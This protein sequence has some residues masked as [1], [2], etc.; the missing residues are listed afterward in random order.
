MWLYKSYREFILEATGKI[1]KEVSTRDSNVIDCGISADSNY[2]ISEQL[3]TGEGPP[4]LVANA[5]VLKAPYPLLEGRRRQSLPRVPGLLRG[6]LRAGIENGENRSSEQLFGWFIPYR[7]GH[8]DSINIS[9]SA[10]KILRF[11]VS[12]WPTLHDSSQSCTVDILRRASNFLQKTPYEFSSVST[13]NGAYANLEC[14]WNNKELCEKDPLIELLIRQARQLRTILD[15]LCTQPRSVLNTEHR[16]LKL[17]NVRRIDRKSVQWLTARPGRNAAERAGVNQRILAPKRYDTIATLENK[18]LRA[19]VA[20][21]VRETQHLLNGNKK[22]IVGKTA[23]EAHHFR[24]RRIET[25]LRE[26]KV[27]EAQSSVRPNFPL[28]FDPRYNKI[29]RAWLALRRAS[30]EFELDWMWQHR[31]FMEILGI[32]I[33]MILHRIMDGP[34]NN[35]LVAHSPLLRTISATNQ[36]SYLNFDENIGMKY[37]Q[38]CPKTNRIRS[39]QFEI[40]KQNDQ[41]PLGAVATFRSPL[42]CATIW[43]N[44]PELFESSTHSLGFGELPWSDITPWEPQIKE[45]ANRIISEF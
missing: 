29:W 30:S 19:F 12:K 44:V 10:G 17:Q 37:I 40:A 39:Y 31:T 16:M 35:G 9:V 24:A 21:T 15:D 7:I 23:L 8:E 6:N 5:H 25:M 13:F 2:P 18:V 22:N 43:W 3:P 32:R 4:L 14:I 27:P 11:D 20:L 34:P 45:L 36:G 41:L 28:R 38:S 1:D 33:A 26:Q 42:Q